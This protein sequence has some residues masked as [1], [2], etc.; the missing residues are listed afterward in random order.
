MGFIAYYIW[1]FAFILI[2]LASI[3][4]SIKYRFIQFNFYKIIKSFCNEDKRN[5]SI[6]FTSLGGKVGVGN[7]ISVAY[8]IY[9]YGVG[10]IFWMWVISLIITIIIYLE[11]YYGYK[12]RIL[13]DNAYVAG[14]SYYMKYG[15][16]D[17]KLSYLYAI[18]TIVAYS[19]GFNAIQAN[20]IAVNSSLNNYI[21]GIILMVLTFLSIKKG[22][23]SILKVSGVL[24]PFML[25]LY[26]MISIYV[27]FNNIMV[28]P[29]IFKNILYEA[30]NFKSVVGGLIPLL[31]AG[32]QRSIFSNEVGIG[33]SSITSATSNCDFKK[34]SFMQMASVYVTSLIICTLTIIII[35]TSDYQI[36]DFENINGIELAKYALVFHL[37]SIG[38]VILFIIIFLFA[39]STIL[40]CYYYGESAL[41]FLNKDY[42]INVLKLMVPFI[43]FI[44]SLMKSSVI[45]NFI[46]ILTALMCIINVYSLIKLSKKK[47]K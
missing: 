16:G 34:T 13:V 10:C 25:I 41:K 11:T 30:F 46:D 43:L 24:V 26:M 39:F 37:G 12:Y 4:F 45:W 9:N 5:L 40:T 17:N 32:A 22:F 7:I 3:Y 38:D 33:T 47:D 18:L 6:F 23:N 20:T 44:S 35:L 21:V 1:I 19:V 31:I 28:I 29:S 15:L 27:V 14:P 2:I 8:A 36:I 42:L